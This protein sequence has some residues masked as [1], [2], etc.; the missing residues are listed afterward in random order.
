ME[1]KI[2]KFYIEMLKQYLFYNDTEYENMKRK[3]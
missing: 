3:E 1:N 2:N